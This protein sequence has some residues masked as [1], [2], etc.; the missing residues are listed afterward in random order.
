MVGMRCGRATLGSDAGV[1]VAAAGRRC[2]E[3]ACFNGARRTLR[4]G[5]RG[6]GE[7]SGTARGYRGL[8]VE[9]KI[10]VSWR[11]ARS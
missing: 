4:D 6:S 5:A 3:G 2:A 11:M 9:S 7:T 10:V 8:A 1:C